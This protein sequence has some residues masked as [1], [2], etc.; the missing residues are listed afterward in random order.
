[1]ASSV[2]TTALAA[3]AVDDGRR[4]IEALWWTWLMLMLPHLPES[5]PLKRTVNLLKMV[6]EFK[7][8][9]EK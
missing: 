6:I 9:K 7:K 1:M 2:T 8:L 5:V 3:A 4:Y